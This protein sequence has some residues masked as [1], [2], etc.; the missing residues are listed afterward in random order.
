MAKA[1]RVIT[2]KRV[3]SGGIIS[4]VQR[5]DNTA[6]K[7]RRS[8]GDSVSALTDPGIEPQI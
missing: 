3:T 7:K 8:G 6:T 5:L 2:P 4:A 1:A